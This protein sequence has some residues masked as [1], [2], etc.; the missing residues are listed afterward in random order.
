MSETSRLQRWHQILRDKLLQINLFD[1][2]SS[3][4]IK[5]RHEILSTRLF[6]LLFLIS[7]LSLAAYTSLSVQIQRESVQLPTEATYRTLEAKYATTLQCPCKKI[8]VPYETFV[9][10]QPSFHQVC[11]SVFVS[12]T[13]IDFTFQTNLTNI[14]P[15][16][17]RAQM[18]ALWKVVA[19]LCQSATNTFADTLSDFDQSSLISSMV[20]SEELLRAKTQATLNL[21]QQTASSALVRPLTLI[22]SVSLANVFITAMSSNYRP[23]FFPGPLGPSVAVTEC[24]YTMRGSGATCMCFYNR[25]CPI[26]GGLY[27]HPMQDEFN[28]YNL[29]Q[30]IPNKTVPGIV[31]DCT[32]LQTVYASTFECFFNRSCLNV[33][34]TAFSNSINISILNESSPSRFLPTTPIEQLATELFIEEIFNQTNYSSYY[35]QCAPTYCSYTY[36]RQFYWLYVGTTLLALFGGLNVGLHILAPYVIDLILALKRKRAPQAKD[37]E[38]PSKIT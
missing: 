3:D 1:S 37:Q 29:N 24:R 38:T 20:F 16:D 26:T 21:A 25:S 33:L 12:Q 23:I 8:A 4:A 27:L 10:V 28:V 5:I 19:A 35:L 36:T 30:L 14:W 34:L 11:S 13:W 17:V 32:P 15:M 7:L 2:R 31:L 22:N 6:L 9:Q 18:S